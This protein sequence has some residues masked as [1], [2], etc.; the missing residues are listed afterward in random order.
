VT[1]SQV[2]AERADRVLLLQNG[3][4]QPVTQSLAW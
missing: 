1:H 4:L 3:C 2:V